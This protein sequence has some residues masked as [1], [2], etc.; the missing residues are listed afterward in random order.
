MAGG[1]RR[2]CKCSPWHDYFLFP[3]KGVGWACL[4]TT[5]VATTL[6]PWFEK[7]QGRAVSIGFLGASAGGMM[8][9][10]PLLRGAV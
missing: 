4:S 7:Y 5:A 1:N 6:A 9:P 3:L 10:P 8:W 2:K